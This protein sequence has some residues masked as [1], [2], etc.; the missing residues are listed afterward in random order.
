MGSKNSDELAV[1][2]TDIINTFDDEDTP[3]LHGM[4]F[5]A[6]REG[7]NDGLNSVGP[8]YTPNGYTPKH[9]MPNVEDVEGV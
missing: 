7:L 5:A 9:A 2:A 8:T 4:I 1:M 3:N 6:Y